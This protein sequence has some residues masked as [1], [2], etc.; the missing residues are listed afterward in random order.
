LGAQYL[1]NATQAPNGTLWVFDGTF[2]PHVS[3]A[4][5]SLSP[6]T[7]F[8]LGGQSAESDAQGPILTFP[9]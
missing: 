9:G 1:R 2:D 4:P 6:G 5:A 3:N 8:T 7:P